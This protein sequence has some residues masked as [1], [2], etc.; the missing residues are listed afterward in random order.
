[1][2]KIKY[3]GPTFGS[4]T[5]GSIE[6]RRTNSDSETSSPNKSQGKRK[7][8]AHIYTFYPKDQDEI[9]KRFTPSSLEQKE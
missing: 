8:V 4:L 3:Q 6:L 7:K 9:H 2:K 5:E 1:M